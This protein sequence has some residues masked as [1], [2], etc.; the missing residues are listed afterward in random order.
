LY[1]LRMQIVFQ[2]IQEVFSPL[3]PQKKSYSKYI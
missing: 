3:P 2:L 1:S